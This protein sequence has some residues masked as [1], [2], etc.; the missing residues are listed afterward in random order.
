MSERA[1]H[2]WPDEEGGLQAHAGLRGDTGAS[3]DV[4]PLP[5]D[6]P[7]T[8]SVGATEEGGTTTTP[9]GPHGYGDLGSG[10]AGSAGAPEAS[11]LKPG[12]GSRGGD[13]AA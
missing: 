7:G 3:G 10:T 6:E 2:D 11:G 1:D 9:R 4:R 12:E 5:G 8:P 13:D